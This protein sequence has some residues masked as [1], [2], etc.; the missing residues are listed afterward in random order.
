M[1]HVT[2]DSSETLI[3]LTDFKEFARITSSVAK[4]E[5]LMKSLLE[6][7]IKYCEKYTGLSIK[8]KTYEKVWQ[9][10][11]CH[12]LYTDHFELRKGN[13]TG[14]TSIIEKYLDGTEVVSDLTNIEIENY[15]QKT[16]IYVP[17][18][19]FSMGTHPIKPFAVV[20]DAGWTKATLPNDLKTAIMQLALYWYENRESAQ[21]MDE[22]NIAGMPFGTSSILNIYKLVRL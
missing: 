9:W 13:I 7:S 19:T 1:Y 14:V 11:E 21:I 17:R 12:K 3:A 10:N 4:D 16:D 6:A 5:E 22:T 15:K 8:S 20:F 18:A 2:V